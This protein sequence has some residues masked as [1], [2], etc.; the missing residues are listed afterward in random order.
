MVRIRIFSCVVALTMANVLN[1]GEKN[2]KGE[3]FIPD[4]AAVAND[5]S[6]Q[7]DYF[8]NGEIFIVASSHNDIAWFDTPEKTTE[9]REKD[10]LLPALDRMKMR[11]DVCFSMENVLYLDEFLERQPQKKNEVYQLTAL[12]RL[13]WGATYNQPYE[14]LLSGEQLVRQVYLGAKRV[15]KMIPGASAKVAY[16]VDVPGRALQMPQILAKA[17]VP[18]LLLSRHE[19]NLFNWASP[20]GSKV[21]CWSMD[22]YYDLHQLKYAKN[23]HEFLG[24]IHEKAKAWQPVYEQYK[25]PPVNGVLFSEDYTGPINF[26]HFLDTINFMRKKQEIQKVSQNSLSLLP[27]IRYSSSQQF[28]DRIANSGATLKTVS[29][30]RPNLWLYIHGPTHHQAIRSKREAGRLL[31]AVEMFAVVNAV[32]DGSFAN[33]PAKELEEAWAASVYD[34]HGWGGKNGQITD[35]VFKRKLDFAKKQGEK[36]LDKALHDLSLHVNT[37]DQE[38]KP[39]ILFNTLSW[40]RTDPVEVEIIAEDDNFSVVDPEGKVV[41]HQVVRSENNEEYVIVF[42]AKDV[43]SLGYKTYYITSPNDNVQNTQTHNAGNLTYENDYY[44]L[45]FG[46]GGLDHIYDK[47]LKQELIINEKFKGGD[48]LYLQSVGFGAGEFADVQQPSLE[49]FDKMSLHPVSWKL[50]ANGPVFAEYETGLLFKDARI[51]QQVIIYHHLKR[52]DFNVNLLEWN[53]REYR[54]FRFAL[55][56]NMQDAKVTYEVPMGTVT[57]GEDEM[58]GAAGWRHTTE[59]KDVHPREVQNFISTNNDKIGITMSSGVAVFDHID[60]TGETISY[61]VIQPVLLASRRSCHG[62]GNW[63]L[64]DG[65]HHY[66]FSVFSHVAGWENGYRS[67]L[68]A[69][70]PLIPVMNKSR[71]GKLSSEKSFFDLSNNNILL[72]T[73]KKCEDDNSVIVRV[74]DIAGNDSYVKLNTFFNIDRAERTNIIEEEGKAIPVSKQ[75]FNTLIGHHAIETFKLWPDDK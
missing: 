67:A 72:S 55:P 74:Y 63:Y 39:V 15:R 34:D 70:N 75:S 52:I 18:Y 49:D 14:S 31:P 66:R 2:V 69:N 57:I 8:A 56:L 10:C 41:P 51:K 33:Y 62:D 13:D 26:D 20:D 25:I 71:D 28:F 42:I 30:E 9:F 21:L 27:K 1:A 61:P 43:P 50:I 12:G 36:L 19:R 47:Q 73:V 46:E 60:P 32:L 5:S 59:C 44:R 3:S 11:E 17:K 35:L 38:G 37:N 22:H 29:G 23:T 48:I 53:G 16:N 58:K 68:Q 40:K 24:L 45:T 4:L 54:E 6:F 64:Q 7:W 65:D